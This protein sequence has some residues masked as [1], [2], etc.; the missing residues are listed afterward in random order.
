ME[1][2]ARKLTFVS[3]ILFLTATVVAAPAQTQ[4]NQNR[5]PNIILIL[6]D[7]LGYETIGANGGTSYRTPV[8]D[9]MAATPAQEERRQKLQKVLNTLK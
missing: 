1:T 8:I 5:R 4:N 7:D 2:Q 3:L 9:R 6:A